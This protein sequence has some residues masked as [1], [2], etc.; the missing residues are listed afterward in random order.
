M[1]RS[2]NVKTLRVQ[3]DARISLA[4]DVKS[5][6]RSRDAS[7]CPMGTHAASLRVS[8]YD[9]EIFTAE[10]SETPSATRKAAGEK[11][12][13]RF[14][15]PIILPHGTWSL[16]SWMPEGLFFVAAFSVPRMR[17]SVYSVVLYPKL[18]GDSPHAA[19]TTFRNI[20][21]AYLLLYKLVCIPIF[22][23]N[24]IRVWVIWC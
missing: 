13:S 6:A 11:T 17:A 10:Y 18:N 9:A 8:R 2:L 21:F 22:H 15:A 7:S 14:P 20:Q 19:Y 24:I 4:S 3:I 16:A 1:Y 12:S 23:L 5:L